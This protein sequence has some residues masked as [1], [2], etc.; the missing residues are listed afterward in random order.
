M[1][2]KN[3]IVIYVGKAKNLK[4]RVSSYFNNKHTGKTAL[5]VSN[6]VD[7]EYIITNSDLEALLLEINLIKKYDPKYN[8]MLR[9]DKSYPYIEITNEASPRLII[10]R[11]RNKKKIGKL[12]GPYPNVYAARKTIEILNR[13]YPLRKCTTMPKK[14]CLYYHIG[15]CLGYCE[16]KIDKETINNMISDITKFLNGNHSI[17]S[18]KLKSEMDDAISKLN[19]EK[20]KE[21]N[22]Y[23][24]YINIT[25]R[26]QKIDLND[27]IDRDIF[28]YYVDKGYICIQV[29]LLR[30]GKLVERNSNIY[31]VIDDEVEALTYYISTFYDKNNIKPKEILV[32]NVIDTNLIS[33]V[34]G[35]NCITPIKGK[36]KQLL[37][38]AINNAKTSLNEKF[39]MINR[40]DEAIVESLEELKRLLKID[41]VNRIEAF[42]NSH[43]FGSFSVSGMVVFTLGKPDKKEYRKYKVTSDYKDDYHI[44]KEVIYRR[45]YRV[46]MENLERPN[47]IIVD[48]G[49]AQVKAATEVLNDLNISIPI[50]GLVKND[51]HKTSTLLYNNELIEIN[52]SS[53]LFHLLERIQDEVH[54]FTINYHKDIRSKGA[55][56]SILDN[57]PGI[58]EKRKKE[59][60]KKYPNI[61]KMKN[62]SIDE[63]KEIMPEN[64]AIGMLEYLNKDNN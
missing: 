3:N 30:G 8:I 6:I 50:C 33:E 51:K 41:N 32:P 20:A 39:E 24:E 26:S 21:L 17:V 25:L 28:G 47:L 49:K 58:G 5:L 18:D 23:L 45:Y 56:S 64:I 10:V 13:I 15:E 19:F 48:G 27:N 42:D 52:H 61:E 40:N 12:F 9:D 55:I 22:E 38:M 16:K 36:K 35:I 4:N 53:N 34:T 62:A 7:F 14:V 31:E 43:L 1:K 44:M 60:L 63:L 11:P 54:N 46:L 37:D 59:I 2:D 29:L 57:I